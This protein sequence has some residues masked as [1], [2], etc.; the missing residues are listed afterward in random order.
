MRVEKRAKDKIPG[1][2]GEEYEKEVGKNEE[3]AVRMEG[4]SIVKLILHIIS[5]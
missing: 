3:S 2:E 4:I 1:E 5:S